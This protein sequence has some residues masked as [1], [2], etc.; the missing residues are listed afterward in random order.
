MN[1]CRLRNPK[2]ACIKCNLI[3][4]LFMLS[5]WAPWWL[6]NGF[7]G[8]K[9]RA[10]QHCYSGGE[11]KG[12]EALKVAR[13]CGPFDVPRDSLLLVFLWKLFIKKGRKNVKLLFGLQSSTALHARLSKGKVCSL[14]FP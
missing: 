7:S 8:C 10:K 9:V 14:H 2:H 1:V 13:T 5:P 3:L 6:L 4:K 11:K 12:V